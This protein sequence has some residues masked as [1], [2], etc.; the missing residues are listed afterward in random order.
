MTAECLLLFERSHF[1]FCFARAT[2]SKKNRNDNESGNNNPITN[3]I[4]N[5]ASIIAAR[6]FDQK[7]YDRFNALNT[8]LTDAS[9][10]FV[11]TP[12][13]QRILPS[14]VLI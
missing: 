9:S 10:M 6:I 2:K 7:N 4:H 14:A 11:S 8:A 3:G 5:H 12:A 1:F 13:P